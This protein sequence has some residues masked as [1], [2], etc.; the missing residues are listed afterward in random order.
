MV[1][2]AGVPGLTDDG[3]KE[4]FV[5]LAGR[6]N[7]RSVQVGDHLPVDHEL[8]TTWPDRFAASLEPPDPLVLVGLP[9]EEERKRQEAEQRRLAP[10]LGRKATPVCVRCGAESTEAVVLT[11]PPGAVDLIG[12]L[13]E[14]DDHDPGAAAERWRIERTMYDA[15]RLAQQQRRELA[16]AEARWRTTHLRCPENTPLVEPEVPEAPALHYRLPG[17]RSN[18]P[19]ITHPVRGEH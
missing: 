19:V 2:V 10:S 18:V 6:G 4:W 1:A 12:A 3:R 8:V 13:A 17:F 14:V 9:T 15:A 7:R 11:D 5:G 16:E